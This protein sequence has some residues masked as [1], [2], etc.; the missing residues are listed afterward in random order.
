MGLGESKEGQAGG[1]GGKGLISNPI[2]ELQLLDAHSDM[3]RFLVRIDQHR[4]HHNPLSSSYYP[5]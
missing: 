3:V 5:I 1:G 4:Y 2:N